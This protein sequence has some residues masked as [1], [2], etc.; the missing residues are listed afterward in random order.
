MG[1][2][3]EQLSD[4]SLGPIRRHRLTVEEVLEMARAGF[5]QGKPRMELIEGD[6]VEMAPIGAPH[7]SVVADLVRRLNRSLPESVTVWVQSSVALANDTLAEPDIALLRARPDRYATSHPRAA[8]ILAIIE[9]ADTSLAYDQGAKAQLYA[10][11]GIPVYWIFDINARRVLAFRQPSA[12]GYVHRIE[13]SPDATLILD[14]VPG[15][16]LRL[17]EIFPPS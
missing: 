15:W 14:A 4:P 13:L 9:V 17:H 16:S 8:D 6:L 1:A 10:A 12:S 7:G 5:F 11:A 3:S 2:I